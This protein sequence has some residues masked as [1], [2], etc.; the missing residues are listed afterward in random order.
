MEGALAWNQSFEKA[1]FT[2]AVQVQ[3]QPDDAD[4][5]AGDIRYNVLRWTSSPQPPFGGYGPSFSNPRTGQILGADIMLEHVFLTNRVRLENI[6]DSIAGT[7]EAY[8]AL[9]N[10][11]R[12]SLGHHLQMS[13]LF[14]KQ[15]IK[16]MGLGGAAQAQMLDESIRMLILHE[17]GHTLGLNHNMKASQIYTI[18]QL[19]DPDFVAPRT[20]SRGRSWITRRFI[21]PHQ[22]AARQASTTSSQATTTTG[23]SSSAIRQASMGQTEKSGA[24]SCS[25]AQP[26]RC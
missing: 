1:G 10:T 22:V 11:V 18:E 14:G 3:V 15:A 17:I 2:N 6:L 7:G 5:D 9:D 19:D 16:A 21:W 25:T 4:W 12:C 23:P 20:G 13:N 26:R 8:N 24:M